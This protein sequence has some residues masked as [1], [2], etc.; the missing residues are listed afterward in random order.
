MSERTI[1]DRSSLDSNLSPTSNILEATSSTMRR[2]TSLLLSFVL[3]HT[4]LTAQDPVGAKAKV[5][6]G[7]ELHDQGEYKKAIKKYEEALKLDKDNSLAMSEKALTLNAMGE[8]ETSAALCQ[9]IITKHH[10]S[11]DLPMVFVTY[12]NSMDQLKRPEA[13]L[14]VYDQAI[15]EFPGVALLHFNRGITLLGMDSIASAQ[16]SFQRSGRLN[17]FHPGTQRQTAL[18]LRHQGNLVPA[19]LAISRTLMIDPVGQ[20]S[21]ADL[22]LL[23]EL[24]GG[25]VETNKKGNSTIYLDASKMDDLNDTTFRENDFRK[26]ETALTLLGGLSLAS[27]MNDALK[28]EGVATSEA[29]EAGNLEMLLGFLA[30]SLKDM[31][32]ANSGFYWDNHGAWII[33]LNE[34]GHTRTLSH[35]LAAGSDDK[36]VARWLEENKYKVDAYYTWEKEYTAQFL[37]DK[38]QE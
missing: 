38:V 22:A 30:N 37:T 32:S 1:N 23:R 9:E 5:K 19:V 18:L 35:L 20:H 25:H 7:V 16:R 14:R 21:A 3:A 29:K 36:L 26:A 12:G 6:E 28:K 33:A 10:G 17:P 8:F 24:V 34:A 31:R 11:K 2:A 13:S 4:M 15:K 27:N